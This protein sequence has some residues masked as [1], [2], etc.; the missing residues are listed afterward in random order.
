[1][2]EIKKIHL[3][4]QPFTI[5]VDAHRLLRVYL[6]AI[7]AQVGAKSE[8]LKEV[9]TRMAELLLE[10]GVSGEKVVLTEDVEFL[11]EQ[12]GD[13]G[14]FKD[15]ENQHGKPEAPEPPQKR[16][17][18]DTDNAMVAGVCSGLAAYFGVDVTIVRLLFV[19]ALLFGGA[20]IPVY[21]VLWLVVPEAKTP[22]ERL[23]MR[24]KAVT[25]DS[26][27]ELVDRADVKGAADRASKAVGPLFERAA[28]IV[29]AV[30]GSI[31]VTVA[32]SLFVALTMAVTYLFF[33]RDD[34]IAQTVAFPVGSS[35]I[36]FTAMAV[37]VI[38]ILSLLMLCT[39][40]SMINR[41]W[42]I[43]GWLTATLVGIMIAAGGVGSAVGPDTVYGVRDR[44]EAS[45]RSEE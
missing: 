26:L 2:N 19:L 1:M 21:L 43:P 12:L 33:H 36:L 35:E 10:R 25:V 29:L 3:G 15:D 44:Y 24:G 5:S 39:G 9:E 4:R 16:L 18:R 22:S 38:A 8:V 31:F 11:K 7:E 13:P 32:V 34:A 23:Q 20:A 45:Q 17:Y 30:I 6:E 28:Q 27:K 40:M 37:L 42:S 14:D 41:K